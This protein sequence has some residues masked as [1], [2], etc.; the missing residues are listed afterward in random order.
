M[1]FMFFSLLYRWWKSLFFFYLPRYFLRGERI[2][3]ETPANDIFVDL[4]PHGQRLFISRWIRNWPLDFSSPRSSSLFYG[5]RPS[6]FADVYSIFTKLKQCL[7]FFLIAFG[8]IS[9]EKLRSVSAI[10]LKRMLRRNIKHFL[11]KRIYKKLG[12]SKMK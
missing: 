4:S 5:P 7:I 1:S 8:S 9:I 6:Y 10:L 2:L 3:I 12:I 11:K